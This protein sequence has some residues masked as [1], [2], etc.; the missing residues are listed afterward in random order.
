MGVR[1][2]QMREAVPEGGGARAGAGGVVVVL[3]VAGMPVP[4]VMSVPVPMSAPVPMS[5]P[6]RVLMPVLMCVLVRVPVAHVG[7]PSGVREWTGGAHGT[8]MCV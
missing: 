3:V 6:V 7:S 8:I 1:G 5:V 4:V 2:E